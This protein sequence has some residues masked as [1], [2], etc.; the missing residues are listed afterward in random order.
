MITGR[1][2]NPKRHLYYIGG[3]ILGILKENQQGGFTSPEL[4]YKLQDKEKISFNLF[5][6]SLDWLFLTGAIKFQNR[7]IRKCF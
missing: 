4:F 7:E 5:S 1:D 3:L 2:I 6:L